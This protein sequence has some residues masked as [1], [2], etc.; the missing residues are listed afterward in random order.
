M[1]N[2]DL[3][4]IRVQAAASFGGEGAYSIIM[5]YLKSLLQLDAFFT[6]TGCQTEV[7]IDDTVDNI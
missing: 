3:L 6:G 1:Y 4:N 7:Y 5:Y 2:N